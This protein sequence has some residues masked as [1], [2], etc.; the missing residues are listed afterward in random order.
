[1]NIFLDDQIYTD[2]K[3]WV[4]KGWVGVVNFAEFKAVFEE[5]LTSAEKIEAISFDNDL[6]EGEKEGWEIVKWL[7][8]EYPEFFAEQPELLIH[9]ANPEGRKNLSHYITLGLTHYAELIKAKSL[10]H[11]WGEIISD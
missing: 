8:E 9:S 3:D 7:T 1:M 5:A 6:G 2:R 11:P 10:P 4:P